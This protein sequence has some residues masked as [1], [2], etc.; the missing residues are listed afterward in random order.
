MQ[1]N[2]GR[3]IQFMIFFNGKYYVFS[4][5]FAKEQ[6]RLIWDPNLFY[7]NFKRPIIGKLC[8]RYV[9]K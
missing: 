6:I 2:Y 9:E 1:N 3:Q 8:D 7:F 5:F 4:F